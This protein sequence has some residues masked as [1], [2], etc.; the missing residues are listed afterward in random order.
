MQSRDGGADVQRD[1]AGAEA[2]C[3][4]DLCPGPED[5]ASHQAGRWSGCHSIGE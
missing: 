3:R 2:V 5:R 1:Q 4:A